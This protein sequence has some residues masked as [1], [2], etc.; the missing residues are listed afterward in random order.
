[1]LLQRPQP[2]DPA[3]TAQG[4]G[5]TAAAN[6]FVRI[7]DWQRAQDLADGFA[8]DTLLRVL[9]RY[10]AR[11]CPMLD[12]FGQ[13]CHRSLMQVEYATDLVFRSAATLKRLYEQFIRQSVL[14]VK[15]EQVASFVG[16]R[17]TPRGPSSDMGG[18]V[19]PATS[20]SDK[21]VVR[22]NFLRKIRR[23]TLS[24][25]CEQTGCRSAPLSE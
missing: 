18:E 7:D 20:N 6:A 2:A 24:R 16:H 15:A 1:M 8:P 4:I 9:D 11:C 12:V 22:S 5:F 14:S 13:S 21:R 17:I 25:A 10:A 3:L 19:S 23:S